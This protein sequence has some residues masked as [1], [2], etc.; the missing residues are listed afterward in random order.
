MKTI[1]AY[2]IIKAKDGQGNFAYLYDEMTTA[3]D[4]VANF[5]AHT[6]I[7]EMKAHFNGDIQTYLFGTRYFKGSP[8]PGSEPHFKTHANHAANRFESSIRR[9]VEVD[10]DKIS[11]NGNTISIQWTDQSKETVQQICQNK[12]ELKDSYK[13]EPSQNLQAELNFYELAKDRLL[14]N[15]KITEYIQNNELTDRNKQI[16]RLYANDFLRKSINEDEL[17]LCIQKG[18]NNE[19]FTINEY[20]KPLSAP[21]QEVY[22]RNN[23]TATIK[24][25]DFANNYLIETKGFGAW[26]IDSRILDDKKFMNSILDKVSPQIMLHSKLNRDEEFI[27]ENIDKSPNIIKYM[28][29]TISE[30]FK[31]MDIKKVRAIMSGE[32]DKPNTKQYV[33]VLDRMKT[34][35]NELKALAPKEEP[36]KQKNLRI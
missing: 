1:T 27:K 9:V 15:E 14:T 31:G 20:H 4:E 5:T 23:T 19:C 30:K 3:T 7:D 11:M 21:Y 28:H 29:S 17:K 13:I 18:V 16:G 35:S 36:I 6:S 26:A 22:A 10:V 25:K 2:R 32:S 8:M 12:V 24:D 34:F 33:S